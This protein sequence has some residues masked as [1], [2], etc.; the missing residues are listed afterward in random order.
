MDQQLHW[1]RVYQQKALTESSWY[2]ANPAM[3]LELIRQ[4]Q[5]PSGASIIDI[6]GGDAV[7]AA[8]LLDSGCRD[9]SVLDISPSAIARAKKR[10]GSAAEKI[11]WIVS[12]ILSF[13]PERSYQCWHDRATFHFLTTDEEV[14]RYLDTVT[15]ALLP[16]GTLIIGT[17]SENGPPSCSG[18]PV[19]RYTAEEMKSLF[20]G[21]F[22]MLS[23]LITQHYTPAGQKQEFL[24][25]VFKKN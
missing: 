12:D 3:S 8:H 2:E 18:L 5:L 24:F 1:E 6:G 19:R 17:F 14:R 22:T 23:H 16:G 11:R 10:L 9:I 13:R 15:A 21:H 20:A 4:Q 7:L 25:C